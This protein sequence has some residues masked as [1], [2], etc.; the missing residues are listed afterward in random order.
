MAWFE[1]V[2]CVSEYSSFS[3]FFLSLGCCGIGK[4]NR[5][6]SLGEQD[7]YIKFSR[8]GYVK[9]MTDRNNS[10]LLIAFISHI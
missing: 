2:G 6:G 8:S 10:S 9:Y 5:K 7:P 1:K 3:Y 4:Q